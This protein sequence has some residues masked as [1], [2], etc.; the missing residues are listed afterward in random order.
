M[1]VAKS[2]LADS[3]QTNHHLSLDSDLKFEKLWLVHNKSDKVY[4]KWAP[5]TSNQWESDRKQEI[6]ESI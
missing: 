5:A 2:D 6:Q 3:N 1:G 4:P